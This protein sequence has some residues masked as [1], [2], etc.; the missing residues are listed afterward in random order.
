M[1][2][3]VGGAG[4]GAATDL[5]AIAAVAFAVEGAASVPTF[6]LNV[7]A[8]IL[9][10]AA[11]DLACEPLRACDRAAV[12]GVGPVAVDLAS[13]LV[14]AHDLAIGTLVLA[15]FDDAHEVFGALVTN[16]WACLL[17]DGVVVGVAQRLAGRATSAA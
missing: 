12:A 7:A 3:A 4:P 17:A 1:S 8:C 16:A 2:I 5:G 6:D 11:V 9:A 10:A 13:V 14:G 15:A